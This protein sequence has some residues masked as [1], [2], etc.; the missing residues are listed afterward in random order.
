MILDTR[1][2]HAAIKVGLSSVQNG[3]MVTFGVKPT[4]PETGY[5]YLELSRDCI[6][7]NGAFDLKNFIEKPNLRVAKNMVN[8]GHFL[9]NAGIFLFRA[10]DMITAFRSYATDTLDYVTQALN[11]ASVDLGFLRLASEPWSELKNISIDH[12]IM[13]KAN[14]LVAVPY[15][16][17]WSDMGGWDAIWSA[18][19][20]DEFG[21]VT[22]ESAHAIE[23]ENSLLRSESSSQ[24]VVGIGL[25][26]VIAVAMPDAVLV[27]PKE[28]AQDVKKAV[29]LLNKNNFAQAEVFPK[30]Y[31]PWGWFE[32]LKVGDRFQ[33]K[34]LCVK[35]GGTLSLQSH[36]HRSE[37]W[38]VVEGVA[39]VTMNSK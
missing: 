14:N 28:R 2:F 19:K 36:E 17:N 15:E 18:G 29:E 37:H 6:G 9:W 10:Q 3:K 38:I 8:S 1:E 33:V 4:H 13:E 31:R 5:G 20:K 30:D 27:A 39:K 7:E 12:A 35:P 25:N 24:Q 11:N 32:S 26:D 21:N 16:S 34:R 23:C 22:S